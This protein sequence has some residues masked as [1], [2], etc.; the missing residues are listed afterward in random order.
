MTPRTFIVCFLVIGTGILGV[1][2]ERF[3]TT[4]GDLAKVGVGGYLG[5]LMPESR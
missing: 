3:R 2:D 4:F 1:Y 5:Q